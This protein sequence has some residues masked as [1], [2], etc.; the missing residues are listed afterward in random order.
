MQIAG[1][2]DVSPLPHHLDITVGYIDC[3]TAL[4]AIRPTPAVDRLNKF[5]HVKA[6]REALPTP[7]ACIPTV[8]CTA[9]GHGPPH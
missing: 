2:I 7:C 3:S 1:T 9:S 6:A 4:A 5:L 8:H